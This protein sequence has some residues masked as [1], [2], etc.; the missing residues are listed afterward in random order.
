MPNFNSYSFDAN[1]ALAAEVLAQAGPQHIYSRPGYHTEVSNVARVT[2]EITHQPAGYSQQHPV[3]Y[4]INE[5]CDPIYMTRPTNAV[6]QRQNIRI[7]YLEPPNPPTPPPI[8][9]KE[10]LAYQKKIKARTS[11]VIF[12]FVSN[13]YR[14]SSSLS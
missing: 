10:R 1:P 13:F 8:I 9:I 14:F 6:T 7:R 11:E 2:T 12:Q 3:Q 4:K 5:D